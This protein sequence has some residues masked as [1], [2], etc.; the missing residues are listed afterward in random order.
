LRGQDAPGRLAA[1][2]VQHSERRGVEGRSAGAFDPERLQPPPHLRC[3]LVGERDR[4]DL[5]G[6]KRAARHLVRN[7][8]RDRGRLPGAGAGEDA[9]RAAAGPDR[10]PLLGIQPGEDRLDIHQVTL[11]TGLDEPDPIYARDCADFVSEVKLSAGAA[12]SRRGA[13]TMAPRWDTTSSV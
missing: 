8:T 1:E 9:D 10:A 5:F 11:L 7:P 6:P 12:S 3:S 2:A 13:A 4:E